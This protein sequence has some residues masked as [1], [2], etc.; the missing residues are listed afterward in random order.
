VL[1][2]DIVGSTE[3]ASA[4]GDRHWNDLLSVH[5]REVRA[6]IE[7]HGGREVATA[8][9][10]FLVTFDGPERAVR[11]AMAA[12]DCVRPI[13]LHIRAGLHTGEVIWSGDDV[14]GVAVHL[15]A[16]VAALAAPDEVLVTRTVKDLALG[17]TLQFEDA[18]EHELKGVPERWQLYRVVR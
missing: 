17:S 4:L 2:T 10:G 3:R 1:F 8:G 5:Y 18:G 11:A 13:G 9:D 14:S 12:V 7:R 6:V 15:G 16:R